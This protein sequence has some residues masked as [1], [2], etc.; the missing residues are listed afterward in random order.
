MAHC[1]KFT[2]D[3]ETTTDENDCRV[4]AYAICEIGNINNFIYGNNIE[5]FIK[6][7]SD[8][9]ENYQIYFHNLKFDGEY[10]FNYL[11]SN[12]YEVIKDKRKRRDKTFTCLISDMGQF[13]SIEIYFHVTKKHTNKVTIYDSMKIL[14]FSVEKIAKD[15]NLPIQKLELDYKEKREVGHILTEHEIEYIRNDVEIMARALEYMFNEKL[16]KMT[17]GS[18]ALANYK[19]MNKNFSKYFPV[20]NIEIDSDIRKSYKGGFTYLN[21]IYKEQETGEGLVLDVNSLYPSVMKYQYLP[22]GDPLF[23]EG[24]YEEDNLYKL[25]IQCLSCSFELKEGMIPTL[26]I[27]NNP[28]FVPNEYIKSSEGDI[29]TL[30]LTNI[31][32]ELFFEHYEVY[33]ITYH[34]GWKFKGLKGL[35]SNYIDYW[36]ERK[37]NAKKENNNVLYIISKLLLN[38]LY[39][40][41]GLNPKVRGKYPYLNEEGIVKYKLGEEEIRDAIYI[42]VATFITSYARRKTITTSQAIKDYTIK[43]YGKDYYI[44]S[45]TD[46]IHLLLLPDEELKQFVDIDDYRLGAWKIESKFTRGKYI[47]QKCYI[48][49][50]EDKLNVTVAGLPKKLGKYVNFDNFNKGMEILASEEDKEHKLRF[51]HVKGGV[52]LADTDFTIK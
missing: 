20:L 13:Y 5:D 37:I 9:K 45:D 17:I 36:T 12:G 24:K 46:S 41:F 3:F 32:L 51:K 21:D 2:A 50:Y 34:N 42:P 26:Q 44:Y 38:S 15:F 40:K 31:D 28:S 10:I 29:V 11:L 43:K 16:L 22:F 7:C 23:F 47:R 14:N 49:E 52:I 4:W 6:F 39:G 27:K 33:N 48:E 35:F 30:F 25:Y 8:K 1:K 19:Q 18:D